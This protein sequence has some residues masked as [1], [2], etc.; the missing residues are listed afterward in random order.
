MKFAGRLKL[1]SGTH[2]LWPGGS[3]SHNA[4]PHQMFLS[5]ATGAAWQLKWPVPGQMPAGGQFQLQS[6]AYSCSI[7]SSCAMQ[8]AYP[9]NHALHIAEQ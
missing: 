7:I 4:V 2:Q 6:F 5:D 1:L 8:T 9:L 3:S